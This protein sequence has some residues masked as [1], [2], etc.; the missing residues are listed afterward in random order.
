MQQRFHFADW[1]RN[2]DEL[3]SGW[4]RTVEVRLTENLGFDVVGSH[5]FSLGSEN[6]HRHEM[7]MCP[8]PGKRSFFGLEKT[9]N[10]NRV[11]LNWIPA[12]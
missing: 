1:M 12:K 2:P 9:V 7:R 5:L 4:I 11:S 3:D 10:D 8:F 6:L